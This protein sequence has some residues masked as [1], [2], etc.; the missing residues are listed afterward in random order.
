[1]P[2]PPLQTYHTILLSISSAVAGHH[3]LWPPLLGTTP[4]PPV[5][6]APLLAR[7]EGRGRYCVVLGMKSVNKSMRGMP[8]IEED[9]HLL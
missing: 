4:R 3:C 9:I 7:N 2:F 1:M 6:D 8:R 5:V